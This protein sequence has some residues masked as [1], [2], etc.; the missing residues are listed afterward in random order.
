MTAQRILAHIAPHSHAVVAVLFL[1]LLFLIV[2]ILL[3]SSIYRDG[4]NDK[5]K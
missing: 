2:E 3:I 4:S 5:D 1:I